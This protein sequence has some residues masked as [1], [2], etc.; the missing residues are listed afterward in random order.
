VH[1]KK[2]QESMK[3]LGQSEVTVHSK[4]SPFKKCSKSW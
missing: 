1:L 4:S 2:I 3:S